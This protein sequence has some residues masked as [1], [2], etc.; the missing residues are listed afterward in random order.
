MKL[1]IIVPI[2]NVEKQLPKCLDSLL[3]QESSELSIQLI[4]V[5]DGSTDNSGKV[6]NEYANKYKDK[7]LY[8]EKQNGGLSEARNFGVKHANGDYIA[9]V[10]SDDY[11]SEGLYSKFIPYMNENYDMVKIKIATVNENGKTIEE[12]YSPEFKNK[13]GEEAFAILYKS[14][15]L[16]EVAWGYIYKR[17]FWQENNFEFAKGL[18]HEDFGLIPLVM[19][20]AKKVASTKLGNYFYVL[21]Q[22]SITRGDNSKE[23]QRANHLLL[24]YDNMI[25]KIKDYS[26]SNES[27]EH[28]KTYYTNCI[29]LETNNLHAEERDKYIQE[30]KK[31]KM[32]KNI[33]AK[34]IKQLIKKVLLKRNIGLYLKLR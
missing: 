27:K 15:V 30:I 26:I 28:I 12:N 32:Y 29:I 7:I 9:F 10:D 22:N 13:T 6:A 23:Y 33:K 21:T 14:D 17:A 11:V 34:N 25:E 1:S 18:Y 24:H 31:R 8:L 5:N 20:K 2:F 16:T 4:L 19:L 3:K